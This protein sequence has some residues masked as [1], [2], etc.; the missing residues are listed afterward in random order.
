[1][2]PKSY[3]YQF[4]GFLADIRC[5]EEMKLSWSWSSPDELDDLIRQYFAE[6]HGDDLNYAEWRYT[7][8]R[9]VMYYVSVNIQ[10]FN[11]GDLAAAGSDRA[12]ARGGLFHPIFDY[13]IEHN[14]CDGEEFP[15]P[16]FF[17]AP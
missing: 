14:I 13:A 12:L 16:K 15:E 3:Q 8:W 17:H 4:D 11:F 10:S 9:A 2:A 7:K 1:M 5:I 6:E